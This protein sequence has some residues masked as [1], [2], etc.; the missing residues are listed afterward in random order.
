MP[1]EGGEAW[2]QQ[3]S[4]ARSHLTASPAAGGINPSLLGIWAAPDSMHGIYLPSNCSFPGIPDPLTM[5]SGYGLLLFSI[6]HLPFV[7]H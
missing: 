6:Y 2:M 1:L 5:A 4:S 3:C 7:K